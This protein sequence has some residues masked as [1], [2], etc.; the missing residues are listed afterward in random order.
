[1][2]KK[3]NTLGITIIQYSS[4]VSLT[5]PSSDCIWAILFERRLSSSESSILAVGCLVTDERQQQ[6][7]SIERLNAEGFKFYLFVVS[8]FD[9]KYRNVSNL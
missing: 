5:P 9:G 4:S 7:S 2:I 3:S 8:R 1:M 6:S